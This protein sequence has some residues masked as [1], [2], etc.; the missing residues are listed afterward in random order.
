MAFVMSQT[1]SKFIIF[2]IVF[3]DL[4]GFGT[5]IPMLPF[6]GR[7]FG[8]DSVQI[9]L[10]MFV[11]SGAQ[12]LVSPFWGQLSDRLG[13]RPI[14]L[15]TI[16]GQAAA[17]LWAGF[18]PSF[19]SLLVSRLFAGIFAA[20]IST[21]NAYMA[22]IS[23]PE[24]RAKSMGL[25]G[26]A[27]GLGFIFGPAIGGFLIPY[28]YEWPSFFSA[29]LGAFNLILAAILL[30]EPLSN[31]LS[32]AGNR[33]RLS[34]SVYKESFQNPKLMTPMILFFLLTLAFVQLEVTFGLF[35]LDRFGLR[36]REVGFMFAGM[37]IVM[38]VVQGGLIGRVVK[39]MGEVGTLRFGLPCIALGLLGLIV[40]SQLWV[41]C[42]SLALMSIGYSLSN[43]CLS[44][45][46][47]KNA[48]SDRQGSVLGIYQSMG[49]FAR[50]LGPL[51][52]GTLYKYSQVGAFVGSVVLI[53]V[54]KIVFGLRYPKS[55][56]ASS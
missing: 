6:F 54:A 43:P 40:S 37:G 34:L 33:R 20:N 10:L 31:Q 3:V 50:V 25:I 42:A 53:L 21:A 11:Y 47:S 32:R 14:L 35:V 28:G 1:P 23:K 29:G 15:V 12:I 44:A 8:A 7:H 24:D 55:Y 4:L 41:M 22:D 26:A 27:F 39:K 5:M 38:A 52:G 36:E 19:E 48:A 49:S 17:F 56:T 16:A 18:A 51:V 13:R 45:M 30:K 46:T 2:L 9:G